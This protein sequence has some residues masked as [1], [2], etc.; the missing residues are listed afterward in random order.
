MKNEKKEKYF[1]ALIL[2]GKSRFHIS[3]NNEKCPKK[4][5]H[6][7][8]NLQG[9]KNRYASLHFQ[10]NGSFLPQEDDGWKLSDQLHYYCCFPEKNY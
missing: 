2:K 7:I 5:G 6:P 4:S 10:N 3:L 9:L 1:K 8:A